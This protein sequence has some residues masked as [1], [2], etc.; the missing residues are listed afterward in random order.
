M[1]RAAIVVDLGFGDAGKGI[2]TDALVRDLGARAVVRFN[3][4]A[5]AGHNVVSPDGRHYFPAFPYTSYQRMQVADIRDLF[6]QNLLH[7]REQSAD[8]FEVHRATRIHPVERLD[9]SSEPER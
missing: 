2:V 3:G 7:R 5:Q 8:G 4:G 1:D 9:S 6:G